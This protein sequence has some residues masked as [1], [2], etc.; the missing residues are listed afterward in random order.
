MSWQLWRQ[1]DNGNC[2]LVGAFAS[3]EAAEHK[4]G[5]LTRYPHKQIYWI[6]EVSNQDVRSDLPDEER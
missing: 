4:L 5:E 1:D 6:D 3:V 2:F